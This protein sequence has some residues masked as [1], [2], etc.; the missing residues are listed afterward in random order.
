M[1]AMEASVEPQRER[2]VRAKEAAE[3][4]GLG[5][6]TFYSVLKTCRDFP[7]GCRLGASRMWLVSDLLN[8]VRRQQEGK[9]ARLAR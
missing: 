3:I 2:A 6:T 1:N 5:R 7:Q 8:W 9:R 4:L